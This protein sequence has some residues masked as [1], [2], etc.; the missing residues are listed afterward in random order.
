MHRPPAIGWSDDEAARLGAG[1]LEVVRWED[2]DHDVLRRRAREIP[3]GAPLGDLPQRLEEAMFREDGVGL[4]APQVGLSVR[5]AALLVGY[6]TDAPTPVVVINP[7]ITRRADA[8]VDSWEGCLSVP[9][10]GARVRRYAWIEVEYSDPSW[11]SHEAR[12][13]GADAILWQHELDHLDGVLY[14]DRLAG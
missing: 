9:G 6:R 11:T 2:E 1:P 7:V 12:V 14:V 10:K 13:E 8:L 3:A 5:A 4:A